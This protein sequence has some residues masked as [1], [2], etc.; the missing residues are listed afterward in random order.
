MKKM[1]VVLITLGTVM[2]AVGGAFGYVKWKAKQ[3]EDSG[4]GGVNMPNPMIECRSEQDFEIYGLALKTPANAKNVRYFVISEKIAEIQCEIDG[5]GYS[6]RASKE[7]ADE[8]LSGVYGDW[9]QQNVNKPYTVY[10]VTG[11]PE[12]NV[13]CWSTN[14]INYTVSAC[15]SIEVLEGVVD[16]YRN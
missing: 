10:T 5:V 16:N 15:A 7:F 3:Q 13:A 1:T 8:S 9:I 11:D 2:L 4:F 14:G 12:C 6:F